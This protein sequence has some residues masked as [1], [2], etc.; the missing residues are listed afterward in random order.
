[1]NRPPARTASTAGSRSVAIARLSTIPSAPAATAAR[2][3][4]GSSWTLSSS[5]FA[6]GALAPQFSQQAL[7]I[8]CAEGKIHNHHGGPQQAG[9]FDQRCFVRH[10]KDTVECRLE[11]AADTFAEPVM[12]VRQ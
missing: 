2:R 11:Q 5:T 8:A 12:T 4:L 7:D 1:M 10:Q 6:P 9:P 3:T